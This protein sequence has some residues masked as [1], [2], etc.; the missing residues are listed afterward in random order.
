MKVPRKCDE[1]AKVTN[2]P[3]MNK[4]DSTVYAIMVTKN[5]DLSPI[6]LLKYL[7]KPIYKV[8]LCSFK[9]RPMCDY[10][11]KIFLSTCNYGPELMRS[12]CD[13]AS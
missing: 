4:P 13:H 2:K 12:K 10:G 9:L 7:I 6:M 5:I 1:Y 8:R 11:P 3:V